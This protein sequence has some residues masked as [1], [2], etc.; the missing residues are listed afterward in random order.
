MGYTRREMERMATDRK[1]WRSFVNGLCS[2]RENRHK[3]H[4]Y[5]DDCAIL[6]H[7]AEELQTSID[8]LTEAYQSLG[9]SINIRKP[10]IIYQSVSG[11]IE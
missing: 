2:Q 3:Y 11:N 9:L 8:L 10:K 6:A 5:T 4:K 7:T 1:Q